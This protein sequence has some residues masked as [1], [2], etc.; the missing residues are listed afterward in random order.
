MLPVKGRL[1]EARI[2]RDMVSNKGELWTRENPKGLG[3]DVRE[4][5]LSGNVTLTICATEIP[6]WSHG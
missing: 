2:S 3:L 4:G 5:R 1:V 6:S